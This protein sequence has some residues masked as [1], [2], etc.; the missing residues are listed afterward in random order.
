MENN[1]VLYDVSERIATVTLNRPDKLNAWT[2]QMDQE[3]RAA[4]GEADRDPEVRAIIVTGAGKGFCAGADMTML[5][6]I[7]DADGAGSSADRQL[8]MPVA[9]DVRVDFKQPYSWPMGIRKPIIGAI[10][11]AAAGLGFVH[12]LY[13]DIRFAAESAKFTVAFPHRGLISEHGIAWMLPR[14]VGLTHAMDLLLSGRVIKAPEAKTMGL[15]SDVYPDTEFQERVR[16]YVRY[17]VTHSSPRSLQISKRMAYETQ[18]MTLA[19]ATEVAVREMLESLT[20]D[21]F[22]EGVASF[23]ERRPP[24]FPDL[25]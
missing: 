6:N 16:D 5:S 20:T 8:D 15:V 4:L 13:T 23:V 12:A 2:G 7:A 1:E 19:E 22:K 24:A 14:I 17:M 9:D 11:G 3:Y 25:V 10:N 21:H 18:F